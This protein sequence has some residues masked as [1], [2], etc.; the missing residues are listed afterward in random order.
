[1]STANAKYLNS[2]SSEDKAALLK[3]VA[4]HY[5]MSVADIETELTDEGAENLYEYIG[6][7]STLQKKVYRHFQRVNLLA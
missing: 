7:D 5:G 6:G 4:K 2:L 1:M 3:S